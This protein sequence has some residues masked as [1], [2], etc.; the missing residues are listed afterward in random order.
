ML[1]FKLELSSC[2]AL[3]FVFTLVVLRA[4]VLGQG[5]GECEDPW[6]RVVEVL[7]PHP[8]GV[9]GGTTEDPLVL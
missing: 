5:R 8:W 7:N 2:C 6:W 4:D 9:H 1:P 3:I